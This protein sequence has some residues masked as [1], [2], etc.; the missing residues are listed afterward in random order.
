MLVRSGL[1]PPLLDPGFLSC[2]CRAARGPA[3]GEGWGGALQRG[4]RRAGPGRA[5]AMLPSLT[6]EGARQQWFPGGV[7]PCWEDSWLQTLPGNKK[8]WSRLEGRSG[9]V[10]INQAEMM[11]C[12][13]KWKRKGQIKY[14]H[15]LYSNSGGFWLVWHKSIY[16]LEE[17]IKTSSKF[18][19]KGL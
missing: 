5:A 12:G 1:P 13:L 11:H 4:D 17:E 2:V 14:W 9:L 19:F 15:S 6:V 18:C 8:S 10:G 3:S 7:C 16:S